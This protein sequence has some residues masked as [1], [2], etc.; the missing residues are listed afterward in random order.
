VHNY[1]SSSPTIRNSSIS[2]TGGGVEVD[3][4][5]FHD[6]DTQ[7]TATAIV[8]NTKLDGNVSG[9]GFTCIDVYTITN[10]FNAL[11]DTCAL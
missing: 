7:S 10:T 3:D 4:S 1:S 11:D 6:T 8:T 2:A 5:I 9:N